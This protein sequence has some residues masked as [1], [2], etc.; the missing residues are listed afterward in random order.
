LIRPDGLVF[1]IGVNAGGFAKLVAPRCRRVIG[2][3]PDPRWL[4]RL[5]LPANV[6][7]HPWAIAGAPG[8]RS[9]HVN[10]D[11]CSSLHFTEEGSQIVEVKAITLEA[12]LAMEPEGMVDLVKMDIEGEE[13]DVLEHAPAPLFDRIAQMTVEFHD[14]LDRASIPRIRSVMQRMQSVGFRSICFSARS[15]GDVLFLNR[16]LVPLS[17][18]QRAWLVWRFKYLRGLARVL[19]RTLRLPVSR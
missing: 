18:A 1:D 16:R 15:Y 9:F 14:F 4:G 5:R 8:V 11:K 12:A 6:V 2:F 17:A 10:E 3:E 19:G 7:V 13:L